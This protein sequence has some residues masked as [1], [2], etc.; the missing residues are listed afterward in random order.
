MYSNVDENMHF[1]GGK[2]VLYYHPYH[3]SFVENMDMGEFSSRNSGPSLV[4]HS[5]SP[6][7]C[8][9]EKENWKCGNKLC[10]KAMEILAS[11]LG[12]LS[13]ASKKR[14]AFLNLSPYFSVFICIWCSISRA[15]SESFK[16]R[17]DFSATPNKLGHH[18]QGPRRSLDTHCRWLRCTFGGER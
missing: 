16:T 15:I 18:E 9:S 8:I 14:C 11:V 13:S 3:G 7:P 4:H 17:V 1:L 12:I 10:P 6:N 5:L 2:S